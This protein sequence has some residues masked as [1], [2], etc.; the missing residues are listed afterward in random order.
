MM[1]DDLGAILGYSGSKPKKQDDDLGDALGYSQP[2]QQPSSF[3]NP[4]VGQPKRKP[5]QGGEQTT[6]AGM[7]GA[8]TRGAGPYAVA[9]GLG[10]AAGAPA[11]GV[12]AIPGAAA[13][14]AAYGLADM[15]AD[16]IT[17]G[18]NKLLGTNIG[19]PS[20]AVQELFTRM[21][22]AEPKT[23]AE[24]VTMAASKA[25][26]GAAGSV[27][28]GRTLAQQGLGQTAQGVGRALAASPGQQM[29]S[30]AVGGA[31]SQ[32][33]A[34]MGA[35][36]LTQLVLGVAGGQAG[37]KLAGIKIDPRLQAPNLWPEG[38]KEAEKLG[39]RT[40]T[41][42]VLPPKTFMGRIGQSMGE[43]IPIAGTGGMRA[44]QL[45]QRKQAIRTVLD[46]L[47]SKASG[48][49]ADIMG[50]LAQKRS[51][52]I[53]KYSTMKKDVI[54]GLSSP[55][56]FDP[57]DLHANVPPPERG[58][59]RLYRAESPT[60]KFDDVFDR[61]GLADF[62]TSKPGASFTDDL[63]S[64]QYYKH[65]Y[66]EN[67]DATIKY[68]DVPS[69]HARSMSVGN[70]EYK[71]P[72][73]VE[74]APTV[75]VPNAT[76]AIEDQITK[77]KRLNSV[78]VQPV[79]DKLE[80]WKN[81]IQGQPMTA[82]E[83]IRGLMGQSFKGPELSSVRGIGDKAL[84]SIYGPLK[85]DMRKFIMSN[86][87]PRDVFKWEVANKRLAE[88]MAELEQGALSSVLQSGAAT[89]ED[90]NK[91]L[92]SA[93]PSEVQRLYRNLTPQGR[94]HARTAIITKA[95]AD[96][97]G[98]EAV[99]PEKFLTAV[100]K[101]GAPLGV[102]FQGKD[103]E[104]VTGL[105]KALKLTARSAQSAV[106][107]STGIQA[108]PWLAGGALGSAFG[109]VGG[110]AAAGGLGAMARIYESPTVRDILLKLPKVKAGSPEEA[111]LLKRLMAVQAAQ[112]EKVEE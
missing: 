76:K 98:P 91:L 61:G 28:L 12:G 60:V 97:G 22:V 81:S 24:R 29:V 39:I 21:G 109:T 45:D 96:A 46:D 3:L 1:E 95:V 25:L 52:T 102:M 86:G 78:S 111:A 53:G 72:L 107:P 62:A 6:L 35:D 94:A 8:A 110:V 14:A 26:G 103:A 84:D 58:K 80:D 100:Q 74:V 68:I 57:S 10:A 73:G 87:K 106:A 41:S 30:G 44:E 27:A 112:T 69:A 31:A 89:P 16:P 2:P 104:T 85:E 20:E 18:I 59:V 23:Q 90:V 5:A 99:S 93:K 50:D 54:S 71:V 66:N 37:S 56:V 51:D 92:F 108:I 38:M 40:M 17:S 88:N 79:I 83:D 63:G 19:M 55:A 33:G 47:G 64:A 42:D 77:L 48:G 9:A 4:T 70:N 75:P 11:G 49:V 36:P 15:V 105:A 101:L 67:K 7:I 43:K 65:A 82:V 13:G 32:A 34:E